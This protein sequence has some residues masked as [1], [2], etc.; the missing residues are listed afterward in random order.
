MLVAVQTPA[1]PLLRG[2]HRLRAPGRVVAAIP[3]VARHGRGDDGRLNVSTTVADVITAGRGPR[4]TF[5]QQFSSN[6]CFMTAFDEAADM[7]IGV[8]HAQRPRPRGARRLETGATPRPAS[9]S[10]SGR[11]RST[12]T[13][14]PNTSRPPASSSSSAS[15]GP[16]AIRRRRRV[17]QQIVD[18]AAA[19]LGVRAR[20]RPGRFASRCSSRPSAAWSP[21]RWCRPTPPR[22]GRWASH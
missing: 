4:E 15:P 12:S 18:V 2:R 9:P 21:N 20:R 19:I 5:Y 22:C 6:D 11:S 16:E 8:V 14:W 10:S 13:P 1:H 7:L 17:Q 3:H